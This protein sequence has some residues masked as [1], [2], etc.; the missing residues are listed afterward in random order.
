MTLLVPVLVALKHDDVDASGC[1]GSR[2]ESRDAAGGFLSTV[3]F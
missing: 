2:A 3:V 1:C